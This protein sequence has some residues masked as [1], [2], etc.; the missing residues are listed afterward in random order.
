VLG[1]S[2]GPL[3]ETHRDELAAA[4]LVDLLARDDPE[5]FIRWRVELLATLSDLRH[6]EQ[7]RMNVSTLAIDTR[8]HLHDLS[9]PLSPSRADCN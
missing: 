3:S 2:G 6:F 1:L 5:Q 9:Q 8:T 7:S 4:G